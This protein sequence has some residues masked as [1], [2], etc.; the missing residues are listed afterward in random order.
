[1][2]NNAGSNKRRKLGRQDGLHKRRGYWEYSLVIEGKR[3][4]FST[5]TKDYD[6]AKDIYHDKRQEQKEGK[7]PGDTAKWPFET[8]LGKV[9]ED[10]ELHL[11]ENSIRIDR[12][13]S[14]PLIKFFGQKRVCDINI[15]SIR[16]YQRARQKQVGPKTINLETALLSAVL[17]AAKIWKRVEEDYKQLPVK[18]RGPGRA[19]EPEEEELLFETAQSKTGW[20][21]VFLAALVA[22][23]TTCR[24]YELHYLRLENVDLVDRKLVIGKSKTEAGYREIP[25]NPPALWGCAK[26]LERANALSSSKPDHYVFPGFRYK[27]TKDQNRGSGYDPLKPQRSWR[28]AWRSLRKEAAKRAGRRAAEEALNEGKSIARAIGAWRKAAAPFVGLRFHD[29]RHTAITKLAEGKASDQTIMSIS[30]HLD[31]EMLTYY[32]HIRDRVKQ[33]A[34]DA[35]ATYHPEKP[36]VIPVTGRVQ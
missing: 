2:S 10:R 13:R 6:E 19:L 29:L 11:S 36:A 18:K 9:K 12:E 20:D 1:M 15:D 30:G 34:V 35:I 23:N 32:S 27:H 31:K 14:D 28:S 25:L 17:K 22:S 5:G 3:R 24:G 4:F 7:L 16:A 26:L 33:K 21:A 8:L